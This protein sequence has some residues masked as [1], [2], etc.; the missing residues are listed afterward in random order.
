MKMNR[1]IA[2]SVVDELN[3]ITDK[4]SLWAFHIFFANP[5]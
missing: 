1:I 3:Y 4:L 2:L 5:E